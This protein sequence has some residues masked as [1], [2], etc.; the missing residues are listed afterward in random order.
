[1]E[2]GP[3]GPPRGA[4]ELPPL[5]GPGL[6]PGPGLA[7]PSGSGAPPAR[8]GW[9]LGWGVPLSCPARGGDRDPSSIPIAFPWRGWGWGPPWGLSWGTHP[10]CTPGPHLWEAGGDTPLCAFFGVPCPWVLPLGTAPHPRIPHQLWGSCP[11][12]TP[13][14]GAGDTLLGGDHHPHLMVTPSPNSG[15]LANTLPEVESPMQPTLGCLG[16]HPQVVRYSGLSFPTRRAWESPTVPGWGTCPLLPPKGCGDSATSINPFHEMD[17]GQFCSPTIHFGEGHPFWQ[18][19][20]LH[21][22]FGKNA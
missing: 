22:I 5:P 6:G 16:W 9:G 10:P 13:Q 18:L 8:Q 21:L 12:L 1:M 4:A 3:R 15:C 2:P 20:P 11:M 19:C 17:L 14:R 7:V